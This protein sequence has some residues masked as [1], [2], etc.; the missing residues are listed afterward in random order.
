MKEYLFS[1][2]AP[3]PN[4]PLYIERAFVWSDFEVHR[5][6]FSELV[7][8]TGGRSNHI[9]DGVS[10]PIQE[11]DVYVINKGVSHGF[12]DSD[13]L[14]LFNIMF[15]GGKVFSHHE[16]LKE[17]SGFQALFILEPFYRKEHQ[18]RSKLQLKAT[19]LLEVI[20][21][22]EF[23]LEEYKAAG[24]GYESMVKSTIISLVVF[25]S[26]QYA[27]SSSNNSQNLLNLAQTVAHIQKNYMQPLSL[28]LLSEMSH[29]SVRHFIRVFKHN[30]GMTPLEYIIQLRLRQAC[31]LM[32]EDKDIKE[33]AFEVGFSDTNYFSR[34][35]RQGMGISPSQYRQAFALS[36]LNIPSEQIKRSGRKKK[37]S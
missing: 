2:I 26:R 7:I 11:G 5:H 22:V 1:E 19:A 6:D 34:A 25:L 12:S 16:D 35:F 33:I 21:L 18:F 4:I 9:I 23:S 31:R 8:I 15:D 3:H 32:H 24:D 29:L 30:Y 36:P 27:M 17:M 14:C 13:N 20:R 28:K 10:Y 37:R